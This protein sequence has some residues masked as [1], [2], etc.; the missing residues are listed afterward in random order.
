MEGRTCTIWDHGIDMGPTGMQ[1]LEVI[2]TR[3]ETT[4]HM[5]PPQWC[6][7]QKGRLIRVAW[8]PSVI[9]HTS[10]VIFENFLEHVRSQ[11]PIESENV[12]QKVSKVFGSSNNSP[13]LYALFT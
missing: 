5:V 9:V 8:Y 3:P 2:G 1:W 10:G 6:T 7:I 4:A 12:V 13:I 11:N